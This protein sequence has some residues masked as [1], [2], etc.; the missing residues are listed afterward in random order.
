MVS[1]KHKSGINVAH[2][3]TFGCGIDQPHRNKYV[4]I[5]APDGHAAREAMFEKYGK[6]WAFQYDEDAFA[7]QPEE[8]GIKELET[9]VVGE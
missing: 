1:V 6:H 4:R 7:G 9:I 8:Y 3:F 2:Y 5:I